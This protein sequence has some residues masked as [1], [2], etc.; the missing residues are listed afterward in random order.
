MCIKKKC[1]NT[2][3]AEQQILNRESSGSRVLFKIK[4]ILLGQYVFF[5]KK[6]ATSNSASKRIC[7]LRIYFKNRYYNVK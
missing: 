5:Q 1:T 6:L 4:I 2:V 3:T 7:S